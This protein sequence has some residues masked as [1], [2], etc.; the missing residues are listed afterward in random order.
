MQSLVNKL[1]S[2]IIG[3]QGHQLINPNY[4]WGVSALADIRRLTKIQNK[5]IHTIVD[6]GAHFGEW[7]LTAHEAFSDA[8]IISFEPFPES[9]TELQK[10]GQRKPRLRAI[11]LAASDCQSQQELFLYDNSCLNSLTNQSSWAVHAQWSPTNSITVNTTRLDRWCVDNS[12]HN[13]D[14]LKVDTEGY[15]LQVLH[16]AEDMF[17]QR[18]IQFIYLEFNDLQPRDGATGGALLPID[19]FLRPFGFRFINTYLDNVGNN[20]GL[21]ITSNALFMRQPD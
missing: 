14:I 15:D 6:I 11:N 10:R 21:F 9:F 8:N 16:G 18:A 19:N 13:I 7:A 1:L 12:I 5:D 3:F 2:S 17:R 4:H 20:G